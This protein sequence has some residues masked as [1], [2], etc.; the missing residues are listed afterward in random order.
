MSQPSDEAGPDGGPAREENERFVLGR[1]VYLDDETDAPSVLELLNVLLR[2]RRLLI[3]LPITLAVLAVLFGFL[4]DRT[5]SSVGS[6]T[7]QEE[8]GQVSR[9]GGLAAQFGVNLS[10]LSSGQS[11]QFYA[12]ILH[13][14]HM[15]GQVVDTSYQ[16]GGVDPRERTLV[17]LYEIEAESPELRRDAAIE[18]LRN[19]VAVTTIEETGVVRFTVTTPWAAVSH[20]V[21]ERLI[22]LVQQFNVDRR[23]TQAAA[24]RDFL[25][26]RVEAARQD[27]LAA[28]QRLETFLENNRR[29]D[30]SPPLQFEHDRLQRRV[31]L[32]QQVYSSLVQSYEDAK[33]QAVRNTPVI[34]VV[35]PPRRPVKPDSRMLAIRGVLGLMLGVMLA[36][37][38]ALGGQLLSDARSDE[39]EQYREFQRLRAEAGEDLRR[40]A[41]RIRDIPAGFASRL[42]LGQ[43]DHQQ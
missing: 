13:S 21:A 23:Q 10:G 37:I 43:R 16:A 17:K 8:G 19:H 34:T 32:Q 28:E 42:G 38:W 2:R 1:P 29:Y 33:I 15:L 7:P 3:V 12:D 20:Q 22:E 5:F 41:E 24:E 31:S 14:T 35:E 4:S 27:L 25:A 26:G 11:P 6:F 40:G 36:V 30:G 39:S 18:R 9:L